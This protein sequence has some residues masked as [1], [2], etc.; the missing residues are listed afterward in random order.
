LPLEVLTAD[1]LD[2][3]AVIAGL[4]MLVAEPAEGPRDGKASSEL[5]STGAGAEDEPLALLAVV[6]DLGAGVLFPFPRVG[7]GS[8]APSSPCRWTSQPIT[9]EGRWSK[10]T[11]LPFGAQQ[12][13][14]PWCILRCSR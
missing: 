14:K 2:A 3:Q 5:W 10:G 7:K 11:S 1:G 8:G 4:A 9:R 6:V 13:R 12:L